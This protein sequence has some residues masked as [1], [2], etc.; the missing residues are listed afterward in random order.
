MDV[1]TFDRMPETIGREGLP[2][3]H[4]AGRLARPGERIP[5]G[6]LLMPRERGA[7]T[8]EVQAWGREKAAEGEAQAAGRR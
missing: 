7:V 3:G 8:P 2:E 1:K 5:K 4:W 6:V